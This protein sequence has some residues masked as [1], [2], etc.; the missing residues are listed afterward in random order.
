MYST[1]KPSCW[2]DDL[3]KIRTT[4]QCKVNGTAASL[5]DGYLALG[6]VFRDVRESG[7][8][9]W[10]VGNGGSAAI[11]S[12]LSQDAMN[13]LSVRSC[14]LNDPSL[15]S[16]MANDYGYEQVYERP[17]RT[18]VRPG[19]V[20]IAISSSG[21]S[22]NIVSCVELAKRKG[23]KVVSLSGF[24]EDNKLW[25]GE[26]DIAFYLPGTLYGLVEVGHEALLHAAIECLWHAESNA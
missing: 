2:L 14:H 19:D 16:C 23:M 17:L 18:L 10:W 13:K 22:Q 8:T 11:C 21:N 3:S 26:S 15:M 25:Q 24:A 4:A 7:A 20:L 6:Q 12:H 9:L 1:L 5:D